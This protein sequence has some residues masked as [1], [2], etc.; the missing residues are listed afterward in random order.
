MYVD[1]TLVFSEAQAE[2]TVAAHA[3]TNVVD[4]KLAGEMLAKPLFLDVSVDTTC[5]SA[6]AATVQATLQ[7]SDAE[8]FG[9]GNVTLMDSGAVAV[10][11]LVKGY[12]L[13]QGR[14]PAGALRYLRVVYTIG[15]AELTAG[16]FNA[17]ATTGVDRTFAVQ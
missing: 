16:K 13:L 2:T 11:T 6:G 7:T 15:T 5:T 9:S 1:D 14:I 12:K 3:S 8:A 4:T 17:I 10:A